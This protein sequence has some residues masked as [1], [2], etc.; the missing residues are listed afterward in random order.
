MRFRTD[1]QR[2]AVFANMNRFSV[3]DDI[4]NV[5]D[6]ARF[7]YTPAAETYVRALNESDAMYGDKG[8]RTQALYIANNL[9]PKTDE[10]KLA[11]KQLM[12]I[13]YDKPM[14]L[15]YEPDPVDTMSELELERIT[16]SLTDYMRDVRDMRV[17]RGGTS[18]FLLQDYKD[19]AEEYG[20]PLDKVLVANDWVK[21]VLSDDIVKAIEAAEERVKIDWS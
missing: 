19:F 18:E 11:V 5:L 10:Q 1:A 21:D 14:P 2:K 17:A 7:E 6:K 20:Y 13:G 4:Q 9:Q 8:T 12:A 16:D 15:V 3:K